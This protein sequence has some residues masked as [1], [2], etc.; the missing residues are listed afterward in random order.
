MVMALIGRP[1]LSVGVRLVFCGWLR[2]FGLGGSYDEW[3]TTK[4]A[5]R[6]VSVVSGELCKP[7]FLE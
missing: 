3:P 6:N 1:I 7:Q 4:G 5:L 2:S